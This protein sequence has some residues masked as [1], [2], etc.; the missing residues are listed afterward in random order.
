MAGGENSIHTT[1]L[2]VTA[3][4]LNAGVPLNDVVERVLLATRAAAGEYGA[5][6]NWRMKTQRPQDVPVLVGETSS[7]RSQDA[8]CS[9]MSVMKD[10]G[11]VLKFPRAVGVPKSEYHVLVGNAVLE[12][13]NSQGKMLIKNRRTRGS[14]PAAFGSCATTLMTGWTLAS[15]R[16]AKASL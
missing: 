2:S 4:L 14:I 15:R 7:S 11:N 3:A 12:Y 5:R 10:D 1:Q 13:L 6:W 8:G 9:V 16:C